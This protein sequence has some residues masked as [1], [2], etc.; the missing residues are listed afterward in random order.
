MPAAASRSNATVVL[1]ALAAGQFVMAL[2]SSVMNVSIPVVAADV[3][4]DVTG[5]QTAITMYT[6]VM[7]AFMITGGKIGAI[8][9]RKR[10]FTIGCVVYACGSLTTALSQTLPQ[11]MFGWSLLEGLGAVLILPAIVALVASNFARGGAAAGLRP[12]VGGDGH[13]GG[14]RAAD[15]RDLHDLLLVAMG[16]HRR[17]DRDR[18]HPR[19]LHAHCRHPA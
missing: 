3:G 6:L 19:L 16:V 12:V 14:C 1:A 11:L 15:R 17:G 10:A 13:R 9:G 2:D 18:R 4:T 7:A 8:I 5:I